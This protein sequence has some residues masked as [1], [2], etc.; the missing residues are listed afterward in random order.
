MAFVELPCATFRAIWSTPLQTANPRPTLRLGAPAAATRT[1]AFC[2]AL[3]LCAVAASAGAQTQPGQTDV[4]NPK[5]LPLGNGRVSTE[6]KAGNVFACNTQFR[7][8]GVSHAGDW[9]QGATWDLTRKIWVQGSVMWPNALFSVQTVGKQRV[10]TSNALP[11]GHA[12]GTFPVAR[13][14]PAYQ[15]DR[16]PNAITAQTLEYRLPLEPTLAA[17]PSCVPMGVVGMSLNGVPIYNALD[18]AGLDAVA[19]EVQDR[20][21]GHPQ[22]RGVYH[23][24]GP[25]DCAPGTQGNASLVGYALDG[26]GIYS[27]H[28]S[29]GVEITNADL[30]AC[31]G[32]VGPVLWNGKV[33]SVYHY[34]MTREYPY[35]LGCYRGT[36]VNGR[37]Q[38]AN[39]A[40]HLGA[41]GAAPARRNGPPI[42]PAAAVSACTGKATE[43][44]CR[45]TAPM[46]QEVNGQCR[47]LPGNAGVFACA[48]AQR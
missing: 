30:D 29:A 42:P 14:D 32:R 23:Y 25:S 26:F 5:A 41:N 36:P 12:S 45:F 11:M 16:N 8:G 4:L 34:V 48:R 43:T 24:H 7:Q 46:G 17:T 27:S 47:Q 31:H 1:R 9:I 20:C 40:D 37:M 35:S 22:G 18:D 21:Q 33:Q 19:N 44:A 15:L 38:A 3:A 39:A 6:A 2:W 13:T 28:D 10:L